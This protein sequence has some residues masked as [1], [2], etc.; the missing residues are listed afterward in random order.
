MIVNDTHPNHSNVAVKQ[1]LGLRRPEALPGPRGLPLI[2]NAHQIKLSRLHTTL[3]DWAKSY[4]PFYRVRLGP[5][6]A[7]VVSDSALA[8]HVLQERPENYR[9]LS[10]IE[11]VLEELGSNGVFS[12]E[13]A[14]W[15]R[16]RKL[17]M[18]AFSMRQLRALY[19]GIA[20]DTER[21]RRIWEPAAQRR[22]IVG[23]LDDLVRYTVDV[24]SRVVFGHEMESL[25][26]PDQPLHRHL[27]RIFSTI[28]RRVNAVL[29]Y[30][31]YVKLPQDFATDRSLK[32]VHHQ[33][34]QL[35]VEAR[36]R[37]DNDPERSANPVTLLDTMLLTQRSAVAEER[38]S[39]HDILS[40]LLTLMLAGEDTTS[41][42]LA[43]MLHYLA[44]YPEVQER[45]RSDAMAGLGPALVAASFEDVMNQRYA[46]AVALET[47]RLRSV[48]PLFFFESARD[49][50]LGDV[51]LP[52]GTAIVILSRV[53]STSGQSFSA[54]EAFLPQRWLDQ[55]RN[56]ALHTPRDALV[57]GAGPR[58]CPG[59]PL[60]LF[61]SSIVIS[62]VARNFRVEPVSGFEEVEEQFDFTM[63]PSGLRIR[64]SPLG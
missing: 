30:W 54:P 52:A 48:A 27:N 39:D 10:A 4:G 3:E 63:R 34:G 35:I 5:R 13:G 37:L 23:V 21:L 53:V 9:R 38:L 26:N 2:G 7:V 8:H 50:V 16:Q 56:Q 46:A 31:R 33:L 6:S 15:K 24:T 45:L 22:E 36:R 49:V 51:C 19:P 17:I 32:A 11:E 55:E 64:L 14:R 60:A 41:N 43:W 28:N 47:L 12:A 59:R 1:G 18:P 58:T 29:P 44:H 61:E 62:M 57:F 40:N 42:T 20:A 25:A